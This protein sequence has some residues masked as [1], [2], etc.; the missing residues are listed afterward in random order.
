MTTT[1]TITTGAPA[2][3]RRGRWIPW[4][5][6]AG[7]GLVAAVNATMIWVATVSWTG[8]ETERAYDRG[9]GYNR[10]LQAAKAQAALGW[11][12]GLTGRTL[13]AGSAQL[14][15]EVVDAQG[16][17][18][19]GATVTGRLARPSK[20]GLDFDVALSPVGAGRYRAVV[21]LPAPGL[22]DAHLRIDRGDDR[23][24][25]DQRLDLR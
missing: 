1:V 12:A 6:V 19:S 7:F 5:F 11:Q 17:P 4:I 22:W 14:E 18:L 8:L 23:H 16:Q 10:N 9:L 13:T 3:P 15:L 20:Q 2:Q 24:V 21:E 25:V